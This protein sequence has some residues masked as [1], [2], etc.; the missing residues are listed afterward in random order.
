MHQVHVV[1]ALREPLPRTAALLAGLR[2]SW[3]GVTIN[4]LCASGARPAGTVAHRLAR[5]G[6]GTGVT[7]LRN[8]VGQGLALALVLVLVLVLE[9]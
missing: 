2:T 3:P 6:G 9:R 8:G 1:D 4:R 5:R 7:A